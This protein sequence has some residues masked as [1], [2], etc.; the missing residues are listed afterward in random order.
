MQFSILFYFSIRNILANQNIP[1]LKCCSG[2]PEPRIQNWPQCMNTREIVHSSNRS[3][4]KHPVLTCLYG[5]WNILI[6]FTSYQNIQL[7][8]KDFYDLQILYYFQFCSLRLSAIFLADPCFRSSFQTNLKGCSAFVIQIFPNKFRS[9]F[10]V[11]W[12]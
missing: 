5:N 6:A 12:L 9:I 4:F 1:F 11:V 3:S 7:L 2:K 10:L 8:L